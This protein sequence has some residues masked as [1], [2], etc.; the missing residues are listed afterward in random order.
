MTLSNKRQQQKFDMAKQAQLEE[1]VLQFFQE[2]ERKLTI[3]EIQRMAHKKLSGMFRFTDL[4]ELMD[5][6]VRKNLVVSTKGHPPLYDIVKQDAV[7]PAESNAEPVDQY[8]A[9]NMVFTVL[10][11][12]TK[13]LDADSVF[14]MV[15][16]LFPNTNKS[17]DNIYT[18]LANMKK[19]GL[20]VGELKN[21]W[22][23]KRYALIANPASS[24]SVETEQKAGGTLP[25]TDGPIGK[26]EPTTTRK[27]S[28]SVA[29]Q[30]I[31]IG[32]S[33]VIHE[34]FHDLVRFRDGELPSQTRLAHH[35]RLVLRAFLDA[36]P[37]HHQTFSWVKVVHPQKQI[38]ASL[39]GDQ[40]DL[41][42][43]LKSFSQDAAMVSVGTV[44]DGGLTSDAQTLPLSTMGHTALVW[45]LSVQTS[46][47]E[48]NIPAV[49]AFLDYARENYRS[50]HG[51]VV[52]VF[53]TIPEVVGAEVIP[54]ETGTNE[55][56]GDGAAYP[57]SKSRLPENLL[58]KLVGVDEKGG[59]HIHLSPD[60]ARIFKELAW[61]I[62]DAETLP[63]IHHQE[64]FR[65]A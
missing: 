62:M 4:T 47:E 11:Q 34:A 10:Q 36:Q 38:V 42:D 19:K 50:G 45:A 65:L 30:H 22:R 14:S 63:T 60:A 24:R 57:E 6:L 16:R 28:Q 9:E 15:R 20:V 33:K 21:S 7:K 13:P 41:Y 3:H 37:F 40:S 23:L 31:T 56:K 58:V 53:Q 8:T 25:K 32:A 46:E 59:M 29:D 54:E 61:A 12:A 39:R 35:L 2:Q 43:R 18:A 26:P 1:L 49:A 64:D 27:S 52:T 55:G 51:D 48:Q 5:M 17:L 44:R